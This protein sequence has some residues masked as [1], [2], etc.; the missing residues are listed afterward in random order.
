MS[1]KLIWFAGTLLCAWAML[2]LTADP[3]QAAGHGG[4][5]HGGGGFHGGGFH[6]GGSHGSGFHASG[7]HG[8]HAWRSDGWGHYGGWYGR[9]YYGGF[10][11]GWYGLGDYPYYGYGY[12]DYGYYPYGVSTYPSYGPTDS[13]YDV[14][15]SP[16][17]PTPGTAPQYGSY[18]PPAVDNAAPTVGNAAH[19]TVRVPA[20]AQLWFQNTLTRQQGTVREFQSPQLAPGKDY[21]YDVRARW[22]E[23]G[24]DIDQ[25]R[26]V[27]VH[28][29]S[30]LTVDFIAPTTDRQ[31]A[32]VSA[33]TSS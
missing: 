6:G 22:R 31:Q 10:Y 18:A 30:Q 14:D 15:A 8:G 13:Y 11:P 7:W 20:D 19:V 2:F 16:V 23:N 17:P 3:G 25:T 5:G 28:A 12:G 33:D 24:R 29:G 27:E 26:H 32:P 9:G 1:Q 21:V 4:G